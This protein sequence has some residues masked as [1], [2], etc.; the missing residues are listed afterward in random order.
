MIKKVE[1]KVTESKQATQNTM[2]AQLDQQR[3]Q[4][5]TALA[6][7]IRYIFQ[8]KRTG[9]LQMNILID[10]LNER[11]TTGEFVDRH[12]RQSQIEELAKLAPRWL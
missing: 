11:R 8:M 1:T 4:S 2:N 5:L 6:S 3:Y 7:Q 10:Q 9:T 12:E